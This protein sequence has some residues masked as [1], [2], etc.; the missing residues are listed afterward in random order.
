LDFRI[1]EIARKWIN[2]AYLLLDRGFYK[3]ALNLAQKV[4]SFSD[5]DQKVINKFK[6][7]VILEEGEKLQSIL[8]L[9]KAIEKYSIALELND[10]LESKIKALQYKAGIQLV[11]L[12]DKVDEP[13]EIILAIQSLEEAKKLSS[14]IGFR[15]E[16]LLNDLNEK[17]NRYSNYKSDKIIDYEMSKA[18]YLQALAR[19]PRLTIGMT[20]PLIE[21]LLGKPHDTIIS[22]NLNQEE[23]LW[24]YFLK[25]KK[26]E[27][28]FKDFILFKIEEF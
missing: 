6:S 8:I 14:G 11:E 10:D 21:E 23:Q 7:Y 12:A 24:I 16:Q 19:S 25:H 20:L 17:L 15:N 4:S 22:N 13:D 28:S 3:D 27:L 1:N 2:S 18:R 5:V 9:G 26:L